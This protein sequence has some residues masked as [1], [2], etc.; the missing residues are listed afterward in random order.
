MYETLTDIDRGLVNDEEILNSSLM[1]Y[2]E[3]KA[4][5]RKAKIASISNK[6]LAPY[7]R[8]KV[9]VKIARYD[10]MIEKLNKEIAK[11]AKRL[12]KIEERNAKKEERRLKAEDR[13]RKIEEFNDKINSKL[14]KVGLNLSFM[15]NSVVSSASSTLI[16]IKNY[17]ITKFK[18]NTTIDL[19]IKDAIEGLKLKYVT[20]KYNKAVEKMEKDNVNDSGNAINFDDGVGIDYTNKEKTNKV[21]KNKNYMG[22]ATNRVISYYKGKIDKVVEKVD[23]KLFDVKAGITYAGFVATSTKDKLGIV[24][25]NKID[26][27]KKKANNFVADTM[28]AVS[29]KMDDISSSINRF[30]ADVAQKLED[31]KIRDEKKKDMIAALREQDEKNISIKRAQL[32]SMREALNAVNQSGDIFANAP[33]LEMGKTI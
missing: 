6:L 5:Y 7:R 1:Q 21:S 25:N 8:F 26:A 16:S 9:E 17:A 20:N 15:G 11:E 22:K 12:E 19:V 24:F 23:D 32:D 2:K 31:R 27:F 28:V 4:N 33:S 14:D 3:A 29:D 18:A 30:N 10:A 13:D